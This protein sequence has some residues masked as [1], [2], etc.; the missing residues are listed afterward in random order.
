MVLFF[1]FLNSFVNNEN[2][3]KEDLDSA[4]RR[5][6]TAATDASQSGTEA[7]LKNDSNDAVGD[8]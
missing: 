2:L 5:Q 3:A 6:S 8:Q 1:S 4:T 7:V